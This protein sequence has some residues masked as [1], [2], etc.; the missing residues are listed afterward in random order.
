M[1][2]NFNESLTPNRA[3]IGKREIERF[4]KIPLPKNKKE[5][6]I[7][8]A[9]SKNWVRDFED[10]YQYKG[11][12][13]YGVVTGEAN[14]ITVVDVDLDSESKNGDKRNKVF[15]DAFPEP[16][17]RF[18]TYTVRT[19]SGGY[20][21]YF[22]YDDLGYG[23]GKTKTNINKT[24]VDIKNN[25]YVVGP[26]SYVIG[27]DNIGG[28][29][30]LINPKT[31][32]KMPEELK[33]WILEQIGNGNKI[34]KKTCHGRLLRREIG[35]YKKQ[36][37]YYDIPE[38]E[39][40][41]ILDKMVENGYFKA[42]G[43]WLYATTILKTLNKKDD[44][45]RL[46]K[47]GENYNKYENYSR[48]RS[49][50]KGLNNTEFMDGI[51]RS[52]GLYNKLE[53]YRYKPIDSNKK[54]VDVT[55]NKEKLGYD[56]I[57][58]GKNYM[59]KSDTGTGKT[60]SM[61]EY[62]KSTNQ[63]VISIVSRV[64]LAEEQHRVFNEN[65]VELEL[66]NE[67]VGKM[68]PN[69]SAVVCLDSIHKIIRFRFEDFVIYIDEINSLID[70]MVSA[71]TSN[72][73]ENRTVIMR[74]FLEILGRGKQIIGTDA[75]ISDLCFKILDHI[76]LEYEFHVN[77]WKH[78]KGVNAYELEDRHDLLTNMLKEEKFILC[79][80]SKKEAE[81]FY[82]EYT[83]KSDKKVKLITSDTKDKKYNLDDHD[84]VIY[85]PKIV[86]GLDSNMKRPVYC[87]YT[88]YS[89]LPENMVQQINRCRN[90]TEINYLFLHKNCQEPFF[91]DYEDCLNYLKKSVD[92]DPNIF[93][94]WATIQEEEFYLELLAYC[95]YKKDCYKTNM[96]KHFKLL[97]TERGINDSEYKVKKKRQ[98][99]I[100]PRIKKIRE[101]RIHN[102]PAYAEDINKYLKLPQDVIDL[103]MDL[104]T[105]EQARRK[106][107][108]F[109][110]F[111]GQNLDQILTKLDD[112]KKDFLGKNIRSFYA[113]VI[114]L[115]RMEELYYYVDVDGEIKIK[116]LPQ[117]PS[118][119]EEYVVKFGLNKKINYDFTDPQKFLIEIKTIYERLFGKDIIF[120]KR[121]QINGVRVMKYYINFEKVQHHVDICA[122][123]NNS[124]VDF[125]LKHGYGKIN[126][127]K[128]EN[129]RN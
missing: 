8:S 1:K 82:D 106:H 40:K 114:F 90:I 71:D 122:Y 62:I 98:I 43:N 37:L 100:T 54:R 19:R 85:S 2:Q 79:S 16:V 91:E 93:I 30:E 81:W 29:Y 99:S 63:K 69:K 86:Y 9:D 67:V 6:V 75:D 46:S 52:V 34:H 4:N 70:Y 80:D 76:E 35:D 10:V 88:E 119:T 87:V 25:G 72:F 18:N 39:Y 77:N 7:S 33:D 3:T 73:K 110:D 97:L 92:T 32:K 53:Y 45:D 108:S 64:S 104:F 22:L 125:H 55:I 103:N 36:Q 126:V 78:T 61:R 109:C 128:G 59:I 120:K 127:N 42:G 111:Y 112:G 56:Y 15:E 123:R 60:T 113:K 118:L 27:N 84:R 74:L 11:S 5:A 107:F 105:D 21:F 115:K 26:G 49:I 124:I 38:N 94:R 89:I 101:E 58:R 20:H 50:D 44:W 17:K 121:P 129:S 96:F 28:K 48:W 12:K 41:K 51:L 66:Y 14:G 95:M 47:E 31:I 68:N 57:K 102:D 65:G 116:A 83:K 117:D 13:N 24:K 23:T